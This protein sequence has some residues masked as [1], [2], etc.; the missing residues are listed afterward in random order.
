MPQ[1]IKGHLSHIDLFVDLNDEQLGK[2]A[3]ICETA[4]LP[5]GFVLIEEM[6]T[7]TELFVVVS[8]GVEIWLNP[9]IVTSDVKE[10]AVVKVADLKPGQIFGEIALVDQ[11]IRSATAITSQ[12]YTQVLRLPRKVLIELCD[13]DLEIGYPIMKNMAAALALKMR[14]T[15]LTLRQ[16]QLMLSKEEEP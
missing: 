10:D 12:D 7:T 5:K 11:G 15:G 16:Y 4:V 14:T 9:S 13:S 1:S 8:G 3:A 2:V 6:A